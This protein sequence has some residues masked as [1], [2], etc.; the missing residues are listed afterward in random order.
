MG[1]TVNFTNDYESKRKKNRGTYG[2][3]AHDA[4]EIGFV[5]TR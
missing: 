4:A 2:V 1:A 5:K 3:I